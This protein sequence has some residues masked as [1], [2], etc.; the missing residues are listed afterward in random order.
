MNR[1]LSLI[2]SVILGF[3]LLNVP[4]V[5]GATIL[6]YRTDQ[7]LIQPKAGG[8]RA[9]LLSFHAALGGKVS[10]AMMGFRMAKECLMPGKEAKNKSI[11]LDRM[12]MN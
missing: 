1:S 11:T 12:M 2:A 9:A 10:A 4:M 5:F 7:I 6:D 8:N 3:S